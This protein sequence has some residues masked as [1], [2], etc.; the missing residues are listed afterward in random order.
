MRKYFPFGKHDHLY[1]VRLQCFIVVTPIFKKI[2]FCHLSLADVRGDRFI[3]LASF[4]LIL[5]LD[6][7]FRVLCYKR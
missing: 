6:H 1:A 2:S 3:E 7:A 5:F 4:Q